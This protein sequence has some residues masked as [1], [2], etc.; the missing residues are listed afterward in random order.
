MGNRPD[1][2]IKDLSRIGEFNS[3]NGTSRKAL[4]MDISI[5]RGPVGELGGGG[6]IHLPGTSR[7]NKTAMERLCLWELCEGIL[8][9]GLLYW[10][11]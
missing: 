9:V 11:P 6:G 4:K 7:D 8:G 5:H 10:E 2:I 3:H 1:I